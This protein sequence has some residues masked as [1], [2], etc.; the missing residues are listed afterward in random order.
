MLVYGGNGAAYDTADARAAAAEDARRD[1]G[2]AEERNPRQT[3]AFAQVAVGG[4]YPSASHPILE[5]VKTLG[6]AESHE[7]SNRQFSCAV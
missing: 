3:A 2:G 7:I 1:R 5:A 6:N 4:N